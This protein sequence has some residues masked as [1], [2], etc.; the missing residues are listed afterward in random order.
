MTDT[1]TF[2]LGDVLS[3]TDGALLSRD[4]MDGVYRLSNW[5]TG[6]DVFTHQILMVADPIRAAILEQ[7]PVL[8]EIVFPSGEMEAADEQTAFVEAWLTEHEERYGDEWTLV[9]LSAESTPDLSTPLTDLAS[10]MPEG[11]EMIAVK[12]D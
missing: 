7:H 9:P 6:Q 8:A 5:M 3:F 4:H 1:K 2:R 12:L 11:A 10:M